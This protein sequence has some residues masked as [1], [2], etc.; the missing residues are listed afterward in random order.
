MMEKNNKIDG[1]FGQS[2][3]VLVRTAT[4]LAL[5]YSRNFALTIDRIGTLSQ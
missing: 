4:N 3:I 2:T 1:D 5:R